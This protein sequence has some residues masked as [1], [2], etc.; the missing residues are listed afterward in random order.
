M[1]RIAETFADLKRDGRRGFI[2]F[3]TAGDPDLETTRELIV[4]LAQAGATLIEL[5]IPFTD[6]MADGPVIQRASERALRH[7]FGIGEILQTVIAARKQTE[8]PIILFSY[9]NPLL[10]FGLKKADETS[11]LPAF[12]QLARDAN[13]AGVDGILVTDLVPE[14]AGEFASVLR[15]HDLDM[16]FLVA[17]TSTEERLRMVAE[18][19]SGFI[20]AVSRAGI[21]GA[22]DE[23]SAEAEKLVSRVRRVS[24]LPVAV[25]FGISTPNQVAD[26]W[27]YADA[28]VVGSA[29]VREIEQGLSSED[30]VSRVGRF[31]RRLVSG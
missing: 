3:I 30:C 19:A 26:V 29:I 18:R 14:E 27:R 7:D 16:I 20:Y 10:Q 22:R 8:A 9:F 1:S 24:D 4:E 31:A 25:G 15:A 21:T 2:P 11:A 6:P 17:P 23:V 12:E 13:T 28:A 5:G